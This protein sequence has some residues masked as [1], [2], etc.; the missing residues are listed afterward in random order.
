M[1]PTREL[2]RLSVHKAALRH[3]IARRR[4]ACLA[5]AAGVAQPL[6]R[7]DQMRALWHRFTPWLAL[8][9][10]P[11][12]FALKRAARPRP[13]LLGTLLRWSPVVIGALRG[14]IGRRQPSARD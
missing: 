5:A 11:L 14:L 12:G 7:L 10:V 3:R 1:Y 2:I 4:A 13:R 8:A 6:A 9:A